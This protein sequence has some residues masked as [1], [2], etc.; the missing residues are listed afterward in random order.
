LA[1]LH[2]ARSAAIFFLVRIPLFVSASGL[3]VVLAVGFALT[4]RSLAVRHDRPYVREW[5][6]TWVALAAYAL[7]AGL[8]LLAVNTPAL[9]GW[10]MAFSLLS[11]AAAW[12]HL[13][14][15][16]DGMRQLCAPGTPRP[17]LRLVAVTG[18][19]TVAALLLFVQVE[20]RSDASL[21]LYLVRVSLLALAWGSSYATV[22]IQLLRSRT[23]TTG[24]ARGVLVG[25][26]LA[27]AALR[28]LEPLTHFLGPSPILAQ[29]LT[30]GGL[31]LLVGMGSG[32]LITLLE[33]ERETAV[34]E[35]EARST[36]EQTATASEAA[37]AAALATSP[38]P[39]FIVDTDGTL[40]S[41]NS[42]FLELV[43]IGRG[44]RL[45]PGMPLVP[46]MDDRTAAFWHEAFARV[47]T[48]DSLVRRTK[49]TFAR[50]QAPRTFAVRFSPVREGGRIIGVLVVS[51]DA[52]EEE[53]LREE[54][55]R[56][57]AWFR[58]LIENASD[59][60]FQVRSDVLIEYASPSVGRILGYDHQELVGRN[61]L[62]FIHEE[63]VP[64]VADALRRSL[65][66][67]ETVP[68]VVPL[69]VKN[70]DGE[71][72]PLE[73]VSRPYT[74]ADG[75][76]RL[77][78]SLRDV[79]ERRR[80]EDELVSARRLEAIGRLAGGVAHDFNNLLMAISGN[81]T[82]IRDRGRPDAQLAAHLEEITQSVTR[83]SQL[84][85]RLLAFA[86]Q[87]LIEPVLLD[88]PTRVAELEPLLRRLL[89]PQI[90]FDV[91]L[92]PTLWSIRADPTAFEQVFVNLAVN[93]RDAMPQG[94]SLRVTGRNYGVSVAA[95]DAH[96]IEQGEWLRV[97]IADSGVGIDAEHLGRIFE[98]FFTTKG[99]SG[100]TG[101]GLATVYGAVNQM[102]G[103]VRVA[104]EPGR[105]T[106]FS[107]YFPR[108]VAPH[109][110]SPPTAKPPLPRARA[111]ETVLLMEDEA[112]VRDVT[113]KLLSKLGYTVLV[114]ED[115]ESGVELAADRHQRI[116][117][118]VSDL[119]MPGIHGDVAVARI[120]A[121]RPGLPALFISGFSAEALRWSQGTPT[122][123]RLLPKPFSLDELAAA[124][125]AV[126]ELAPTESSAP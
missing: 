1:S 68:T 79:R 122:G 12:W 7:A 106:T 80:L 126:L 18:L 44:V 34:R 52:T 93:A 66:R 9:T 5:T 58:S 121:K 108:V 62:E 20:P 49:F 2:C 35:A 99:S 90:L 64:T 43:E 55:D 8:A 95:A 112:P 97:D 17:H 38:D 103:R 69:R 110:S 85:R 39:V 56:R 16:E 36:A 6:W 82:L 116:D 81:V 45:S 42:R 114:A 123:S 15:L 25:S 87:Q 48:G 72:V 54:L 67:D 41:A 94:G 27:Y 53:R 33:V 92:A 13:M 47:V 117:V 107:L 75:S 63:D 65:E 71:Y 3:L 105:G 118:I 24:L 46:H 88:V 50:G 98:P 61:G 113:T 4:F 86:R 11:I 120:R 89:G 73:G 30:F 51:H 14:R 21:R 101:L 76:D 32:M 109:E 119:M 22:G 78:V 125:R 74:E 29:F 91:N 104:S 28:L 57:E 19:L 84:T 70:V 124:V 100:G 83:G 77:I 40:L 60:I 31:P 23:D 10:R 115:G 102:G 37:L 59:M 26:L 96:G 111:G